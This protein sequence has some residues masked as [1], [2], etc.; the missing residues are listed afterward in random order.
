ML[1]L[2]FS[3][4]QAR[5][6]FSSPGA[7]APHCGGLNIGRGLGETRAAIAAAHVALVGP[8][9][10]FPALLVPKRLNSCGAQVWLGYMGLSWIRESVPCTGRCPQPPRKPEV[11]FSK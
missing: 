4:L 6:P 2:F 5:V 10:L 8:L 1:S 9:V 11:I 7:W 3:Q